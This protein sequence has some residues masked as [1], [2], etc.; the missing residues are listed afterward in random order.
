MRM[1]Y[2]LYR[3]TRGTM[4]EIYLIFTCLELSAH[5]HSC[6]RIMLIGESFREAFKKWV[7]D[8]LLTSKQVKNLRKWTSITWWQMGYLQWMINT[9]TP[10]MNGWMDERCFRP[11]FC[12]IKA[13]MGR[14][15]PGLM[16]WSWD[17]TLPQCSIDRSTF[18]TTAQRDTSELAAPPTP[19]MNTIGYWIRQSGIKPF[20]V[21]DKSTYF[22]YNSLVYS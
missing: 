6:R 3:F 16:R 1:Y 8:I 17:E 14:G 5:L 11:L 18:Y 2:F 13:E 4:P 10:E 21:F 20:S 15:Q 22:S 9:H 12:T 7:K 19:E